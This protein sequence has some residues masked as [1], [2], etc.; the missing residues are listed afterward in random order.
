MT[1]MFAYYYER[2]EMN[3]TSVS[4]AIVH[5]LQT[6]KLKSSLKGTE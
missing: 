3:T 4:Y 2:E 6:D 1:N 5:T